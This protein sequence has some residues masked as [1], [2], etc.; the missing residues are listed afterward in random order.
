[1]EQEGVLEKTHYSD[2]AVPKP[3][4]NPV[5]DVDQYP[6]PKPEEIF[7]TLAGGQS[8]TTLDLSHA[9]NQLILYR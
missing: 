9:Y 5:L 3:V 2:V 7:A 6:L 4:L 1:M 8:F